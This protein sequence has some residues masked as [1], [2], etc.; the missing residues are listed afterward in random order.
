[1]QDSPWKVSPFNIPPDGLSIPERV[2]IADCTLRD[3]E[4]QAGLVFSRE[5][6]LAIARALDDLGVDEIEAGTPAVS[7]EDRAAVE[8]IAHAGLRA[9]VSALARAR[10]DDVDLVAATGAWGIRLSLQISG[11]QRMSKLRLSDEAYLAR[12]IEVTEHAKARGLYVVF[13]PYDTTRADPGFLTRVLRA[14]SGR[15]TVDRF[16]L[17]DTVGAATP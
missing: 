16:R 6:K 8:E 7:E 5:D 13:S 10:R 4:Q 9:P 11:I 15:G 1:M 12:A 17:V 14:L 2:Y 3:G